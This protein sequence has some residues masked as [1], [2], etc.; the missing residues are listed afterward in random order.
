MKLEGKVRLAAGFGTLML[1]VRG[2]LL[3]SEQHTIMK[4]AASGGICSGVH[5]LRVSIDGS[6]VDPGG[7]GAVLLLLEHVGGFG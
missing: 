2:G 3:T 1:L 7:F 5:R 4:P 6:G